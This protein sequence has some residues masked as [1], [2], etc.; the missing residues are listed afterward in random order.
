[1]FRF[2]FAS[3]LL[4][5]ASAGFAQREVEDPAHVANTEGGLVFAPD[6]NNNIAPVDSLLD[7]IWEC[8]RS[9]SS[10][11][12]VN[13]QEHFRVYGFRFVD[14]E[15]YALTGTRAF[16]SATRSAETRAMGAATEYLFGVAAWTGRFDEQASSTSTSA[17]ST[18]EPNS[19]ERERIS[20]MSTSS[21]DVF[22][23]VVATQS[24]GFL[25]GGRVTG[26]RFTS[27]GE[28]Y[29]YCVVVR[30]DIPLDQTQPAPGMQGSQ[31]NNSGGGIVVQPTTPPRE[32]PSGYPPLPP[33]S[34]GD[35]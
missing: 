27:L 16:S 22:R 15:E 2:L 5:V 18:G 14:S 9:A 3:M 29:G 7:M 6:A 23:N 4:L 10:I 11:L 24:T 19:A 28:N 25:K 20:S 12:M 26:T 31:D 35:F 8:N 13:G 1:M 34:A 30:Y 17:S 32:G 21:R 33:G